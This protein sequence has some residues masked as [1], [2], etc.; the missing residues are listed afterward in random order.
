VSRRVTRRDREHAY[1]AGGGS[2]PLSL[3]EQVLALSAGRPVFTADKY[4]V[5]GVS[6]RVR[7]FVDWN[8]PTHL[9]EQTAAA[10]QVPL[11]VP[12]ADF[13]GALCTTS[14]ADA[15]Y[16]SNRPASAFNYT[17]DGVSFES[18]RVISPF[19]TGLGVIDVT[20]TQGGHGGY[21]VFLDPNPHGRLLAS[22]GVFPGDA[23]G[24]SAPAGVPTY[25]SFRVE[26]AAANQLELRQKAT[27]VSSGIFSAA[28]AGPATLPLCLLSNGPAVSYAYPGRWVALLH[29]PA[30]T[31]A[32]RLIV[33]TWIYETYGI[34]SPSLAPY[35]FEKVKLLA[36]GRPIFTADHYTV[37]GISGRVRAF[38]DH[39]DPAHVLEQSVAVRQVPLPAVAGD[40]GGATV[41]AFTGAECYVSNRS[42]A[43]WA[44]ARG[45]DVEHWFGYSANDGI[46]SVLEITGDLPDG[47]ARHQID[48]NAFNLRIAQ[49]ALQYSPAYAVGVPTF[50]GFRHSGTALDLYVRG[51]LVASGSD[52]ASGAISVSLSLGGLPAS[53]YGANMRW[54]FSLWFPPLAP[55]ERATVLDWIEAAYGLAA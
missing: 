31:P 54:P 10:Q 2:A 13:A 33:E 12:H 39:N 9:L 5:D 40:F 17:A 37:D 21:Q 24:G 35:L 25:F 47:I 49:A 20:A 15:V 30:L 41:G 19:A 3:F 8:D 51:A 1:A 43:Y 28:P 48:I 34:V 11:P 46:L 6:G 29:F 53:G 42:P 18:V 52:T 22:T 27:L 16:A 55:A 50:C 36:A 32:Q 23:V 45:G 44:I 4:T 38:V 7:A 26:A 14:N